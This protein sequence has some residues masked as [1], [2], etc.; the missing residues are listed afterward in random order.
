[1]HI[2][3]LHRVPDKLI[4]Y[5]DN[6]DHERHDVTYVAVPERMVTMPKDVRCTRLQRPGTGDTAAEVVAAMAGRPRP[7]VVIAL[8]EYDLLAAAE[9]REKLGVPG[10]QVA[11]VLPCRDKVAMKEAVEARGLRVPRFVPLPAALRGGEPRVPWTGPSVLKPRSGASSEGVLIFGTV[12]ELLDHARAELAT[13]A[14]DTLAGWECEE[15]VSGPIIHIDGLMADGVPVVM[16]ASRY[17][18]SCL[19]FAEGRPVG[20]VQI[21]MP[22][23]MANWTLTALRAV[24]IE[25][26]PFH[27]EAID[28]AGELVFLEVGARFGGADIVDTFELATGVRMPASQLRILVEGASGR[29]DFRPFDPDRAFGWFVWPGHLLGT[30]YCSV[31]DTTD[32]RDDPLVWRWVERRPDEPVVTFITYDDSVAPLAGIV[33]PAPAAELERFLNSMFAT[34]RIEPAPVPAGAG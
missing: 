1:M 29:P 31:R 19:A 3:V 14:D 22:D 28:A 33:G 16:V 12:A 8:S 20:S 7:D 11:D 26:G 34:V 27:L 17:V 6:I 30:S 18:N 13:A 24:H 4:H 5:G 2:L 23:E 25:N 21:P 15:F 32:F 10:P 9:V